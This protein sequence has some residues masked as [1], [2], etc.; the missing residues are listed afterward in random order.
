MFL[1]ISVIK[2]SYINHSLRFSLV[3]V[4]DDN[5]GPEKTT[6]EQTAIALVLHTPTV[7]NDGKGS[8]SHPHG[9]ADGAVHVALVQPAVFG[10]ASFVGAQGG[11]VL[12]GE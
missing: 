9:D 5:L 2:F 10:D 11:R 3:F 1:F 6:H 7:V 8:E 12:A 4:Y